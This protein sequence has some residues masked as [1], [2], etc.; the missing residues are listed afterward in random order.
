MVERS[1]AGF[2]SER[3][4]FVPLRPDPP[5]LK[6][7]QEENVLVVQADNSQQPNSRWYSGSGIYRN[8]WLVKTGQVHVDHYGTNITTPEVTQDKAT[9]VIE[10]TLKNNEA[11]PRFR[12]IYNNR[13]RPFRERRSPG[14][15]TCRTT[16]RRD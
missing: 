7:G 16:G 9:V 13:E 11:T 2:P 10:T 4:R 6:Y 12:R 5:Y 15:A 8:V 1:S 14:Y 3:I